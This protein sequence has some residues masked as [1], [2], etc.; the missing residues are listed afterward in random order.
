MVI[1]YA[2][3]YI[4]ED[5]IW[6]LKCINY[7]DQSSADTSVRGLSESES[8]SDSSQKSHVRVHVQEL[9]FSSCPS[10]RLS[11][12]R[13]RTPVSDL[14]RVRVRQT[15][16]QD[17]LQKHLNSKCK[18]SAVINGEITSDNQLTTVLFESDFPECIELNP[19]G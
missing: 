5:F 12:I 7:T 17:K 4:V 11:R 3:D 16:Y 14:V 1:I 9:N 19:E 15:L 8:A 18:Q 13:T 10:P 2:I 6:V